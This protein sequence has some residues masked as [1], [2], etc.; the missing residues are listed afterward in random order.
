VTPEDEGARVTRIVKYMK[1]KPVIELTPNGLGVTGPA[2]H[3]PGKRHTLLPKRFDGCPGRAGAFE[4]IEEQPNALL[5][6]EVRIKY[7]ATS[8]I[9]GEA[10]GQSPLQL[11]SPRLVQDAAAQ[12]GPEHVQLGFTHRALEAQQQTIVEVSRVVDAILIQDQ[13]I[14]ESADL[15]QPVPV[16]RVASKARDLEPEDD[17]RASHP[18]LRNESLKAL[19]VS[20]RRARLAEVGINHDDAFA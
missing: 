16:R 8:R 11:A 18:D 4:S 13:R 19:T 20:G 14:R 5:H 2:V 7:D 6:S 3:V 9:I 10:H 12:T 17:S 15:E 1:H